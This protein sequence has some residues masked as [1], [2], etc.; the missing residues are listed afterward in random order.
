MMKNWSSY[1]NSYLRHL[2]SLPGSKD[3]LTISMQSLQELQLALE[4][5]QRFVKLTNTGKENQAWAI[6]IS[7]RDVDL[8]EM[9]T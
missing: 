7:L 6:E 8:K 2:K 9:S 4:A 1:G 5:I 3:K